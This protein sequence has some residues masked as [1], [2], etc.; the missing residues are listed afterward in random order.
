MTNLYLF[1]LADLCSG[2]ENY[3]SVCIMDYSTVKLALQAW[4]S[5]HHVNRP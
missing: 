3:S 2:L 5:Q 4:N 1:D